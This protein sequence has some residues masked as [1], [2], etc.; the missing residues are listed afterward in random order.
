MMEDSHASLPMGIARQI[1]A[2]CDRFEEAWLGNQRPHIE[3]CLTDVDE[4]HRSTLL[5]EL[6]RVELECRLRSEDA[7]AVEDYRRRFPEDG[8]LV[9]LLLRQAR[10]NVESLSEAHDK[11]QF[12]ESPASGETGVQLSC[13]PGTRCVP[14]RL[15]N[16]EPLEEIDQGGMEGVCRA[17][18]LHLGS[19]GAIKE[20]GPHA[21]DSPEA[22]KLDETDVRFHTSTLG[23]KSF[24]PCQDCAEAGGTELGCF[25]HYQMLEEIGRG[26]MGIVYRA[27]QCVAN[28]I[29]ALKVIRND[30]FQSLPSE[31]QTEVLNRFHQEAHAAA[32]LQHE[33]IITVYE[34]GET[35]GQPFFSMR[36]VE[37][38]SLGEM[39]K[40][41]PL[42]PRSAARYM[43]Q[44]A[45]AVQ[46]AHEQG[47]LHRDLKPQNIVVEQATDH[48]LVTDFGLAKLLEGH[49]E[50]TRAGSVL[51]TPAYMSPEQAEG[52]AHVGPQA[53]VYG[54]GA[55]LYGVLT[56]RPPFQAATPL[57]TLRQ[58]IDAEPVGPSALNRAINRD[59]E[60]IC[61]KSLCK[62]PSR[63]Y[64][65]AADL[66]DDLARYLRSEPIHARPVGPLE[67][68]RRWCRRNPVLAGL[69][70][71]AVLGFS[72]AL[73]AS[74]VG[75]VQTA[76]ALARSDQS[77]REARQSV[78]DLFTDLSEETL[79]NEPGMQPLRKKLLGRALEYYQRFVSR[80]RDDSALQDELATAYFRVGLITQ[81]IDSPKQ[82]IV[83]YQRARQ[84]QQQL[85]DERRDTAR[86][87]SLGNTATA[88]GK[89]LQVTGEFDDAQAAYQRA[90]GIREELT[91]RE[92][93]DSEYRR[94]YANGLMNLG[95][96]AK[97]R[98]DAVQTQSYLEAAQQVR[99][100]HLEQHPGNSSLR[101]D[102]GKGYVNLALIQGGD[103]QKAEPFLRKAVDVFRRLITE[104]AR[105]LENQ[106]R[107]AICFRLLGDCETDVSQALVSYRE[108]ERILESLTRDNPN[109]DSFQIELAGLLMNQAD[110]LTACQNE[111]AARGAFAEA[112]EVLER[113]VAKTPRVPRY[114]R[115]LAVVLRAMAALDQAQGRLDDA[116]ESLTE[117]ID[118]LDYLVAES[119]D[120]R[121]Y[122]DL[123][124]STAEM[125][126]ELTP[127]SSD[128]A[129]PD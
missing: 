114:R 56:A 123:R 97:D 7:P 109:V 46:E 36:Y 80:H 29:V 122:V 76:D 38:T 91:Q 110:C 59:L 85:V 25:G 99:E 4:A 55:T 112:R 78:D 125:L 23:S 10:R 24:D 6:L 62:D 67:R 61:L 2:I 102:L 72:A 100:R 5:R 101:R 65:S 43:E 21:A 3:D 75:Y 127:E 82:A 105:D 12:L 26:G 81:A 103:S 47:I 33:H 64:A 95:L 22:V 28:R 20:L 68:G 115:D 88:L 79:L 49:D 119:P 41:G 15:D 98:G 92:P 121:E 34:V 69:T 70:L 44:V 60:T 40:S 9:E 1:D 13:D 120:V 104:D 113:L 45:R 94:L 42:D 54:L 18:D 107:L 71:L 11:C 14:R 74:T 58:V 124:I 31:M 73:V 50:L 117:S 108:A 86:L 106:K 83:W 96:L 128:A 77:L 39:L 19:L 16:C 87:E 52:A 126:A 30:R 48:A 111:S 53:D 51:G 35:D 63:R 90:V 118:V 57:E 66:A 129:S 8:E 89:A 17:H 84:L 37:G 116:R 32:K 27:R 93:A